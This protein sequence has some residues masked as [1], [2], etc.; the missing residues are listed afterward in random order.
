MAPACNPMHRSARC[1]GRRG[2]TL[3]ELMIA[4]SIISVIAAI[5]IPNAVR[6]QLSARE[7]QAIG[8]MKQYHVAQ[9]QFIGSNKRDTNGDG[10]PD[11]GSFSGLVAAGGAE[12]GPAFLGGMAAAPMYSSDSGGQAID[13]WDAYGYRMVAITVPQTNVQAADYS[14]YAIPFNGSQSGPRS[15]FVDRSGVV[16]SALSPEVAGPTSS[17]L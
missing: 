2:F 13:V 6:A 4:V 3:L 5:A 16:R 11:Y 1:L 8:L 14:L 17:P 12:D 7:A 9:T 15:F 10:V